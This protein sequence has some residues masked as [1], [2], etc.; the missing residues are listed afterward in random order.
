MSSKANNITLCAITTQLTL[1][2]R[3]YRQFFDSIRIYAAV[4]IQTIIKLKVRVLVK[5]MLHGHTHLFF[6][7]GYPGS[8][9]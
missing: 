9:W 6:E 4:Q 5:Q 8:V 2:M 3:L 1:V 7:F